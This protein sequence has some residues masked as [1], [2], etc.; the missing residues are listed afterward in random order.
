MMHLNYNT[1]KQVGAMHFQTM[2][3]PALVFSYII[4]T[5]FRS[6]L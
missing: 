1:K 2:H 4:F 6:L 5:R 3:K